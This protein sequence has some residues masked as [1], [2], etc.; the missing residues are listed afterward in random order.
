LHWPPAPTLPPEAVE[1]TNLGRFGR[2]RWSCPSAE[3]T[4][5]ISLHVSILAALSCLP[6]SPG[7]APTEQGEVGGKESPIGNTIFSLLY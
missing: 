5:H 2:K 4:A 7:P 6:A 3:P 1:P